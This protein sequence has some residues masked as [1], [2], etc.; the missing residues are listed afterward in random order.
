MH[1]GDRNTL[2]IERNR[3]GKTGKINIL[4]RECFTNKC[5]EQH[6][7]STLLKGDNVFCVL[8]TLYLLKILRNITDQISKYPVF[9]DFAYLL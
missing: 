8:N 4:E 5:T 3:K 7:S 6:F 2:F 1:K 9:T